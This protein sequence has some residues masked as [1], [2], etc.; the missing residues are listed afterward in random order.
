MPKSGTKR[1]KA[2]RQSETRK[3]RALAL[4]ASGE[5]VAATARML[6]ITPRTVF[7][8]REAP[9]F[10]ATLAGLLAE[11][12]G[13]TRDRLRA[14]S[15]KAVDLLDAELSGSGHPAIRAA[16]EVLDRT[17]GKPTQRLEH[18]ERDGPKVEVVTYL[19]PDNG[20]YNPD[21]TT[22]KGCRACGTATEGSEE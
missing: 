4:L 12:E 1:A 5:S 7:R 14:L 18:D 13:E 15:A 2:R 20:R 11:I 19:I 6:K 8:W 17:L 16:R 3:E 9:E 21:A 22:R 10:G